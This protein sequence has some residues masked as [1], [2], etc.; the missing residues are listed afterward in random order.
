MNMANVRVLLVDDD[1]DEYLLVRRYLSHARTGSFQVNWVPSIEAALGEME[2]ERYD[3]CLLDYQLGEQTGLELLR[4]MRNR[5]YDLPVV[6]LTG[7]G[8]LELDLSA[9]ESGAFEYL[10]K[11]ELTPSM[12]ERTIRYTLAAHK[13]RMDLRKANEE[14]ERRVQE[15][16]AE[17]NRSNRE[18][19]QFARMV[20]SDLQ[21]PLHALDRQIEGLKASA[22]V[23]APGDERPPLRA[24]LDSVLQAVRNMEL[25]IESILDYSQVG[26]ETRP[27]EPV[28]LNAAFE[29][30]RAQLQGPLTESGTRV[31]VESLP[32]VRGNRELLRGLFRN[33]LDNAIRFRGA[34]PPEVEVWAE[35]KGSMW[36]V[37]VRDNGVGV[38]PEEA[39]EIFMMFHKGSRHAERAGI[40]MGLAMC[41]KIVQ[42]HG[43][44]IWVD[45]EPGRGSTFCFSLPAE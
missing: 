25:L 32:T 30:A 34:E 7:H 31:R 19:E 44:R 18:L 40:G 23:P 22:D 2:G 15:R 17:L 9:M 11:N 1:E 27:L 36:L 28:D 4:E 21:E 29:E 35:R 26:R 41:R 8:S 42:Y 43:G 14:L 16:T 33:L 6:L 10:E 3:V 38:D 13:A 37:R 24:A 20:A 12:L 5:G 45:G 39:G